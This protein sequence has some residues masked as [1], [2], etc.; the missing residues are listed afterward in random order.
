MKNLYKSVSI[1]SILLLVISSCTSSKK[2]AVSCPEPVSTYKSKAFKNHHRKAYKI[3]NHAQRQ[4]Q[5]DYSNKKNVADVR[6]DNSSKSIKNP[7][8]IK[9]TLPE[10]EEFNTSASE[11]FN[12]IYASI[13]QNIAQSLKTSTLSDIES[14]VSDFE[15]TDPTYERI[16]A[17]PLKSP[18]NSS[19]TFKNHTDDILYP[20]LNLSVS[21]QEQ[22][23]GPAKIE[24]LGLAGF[25]TSLAGLLILPIPCGI[26]GI[27]LSGISLGRINK[28][29]GKYRGKGFAIAGLIVGIVMVV[30]GAVLI[31]LAFM[32]IS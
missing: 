20:A 6:V 18:I 15:T 1:I 28:N 29:P 11:Y 24:P 22:E 4:N 7:N 5:W 10:K 32:S 19:I 31:G 21:D 23:I 3:H 17:I 12:N 14:T 8:L 30:L 25:I 26:V 16:E 27:V 2:M 9:S 13:D